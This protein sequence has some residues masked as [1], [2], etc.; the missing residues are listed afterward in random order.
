MPRRSPNREDVEAGAED[1]DRRI[2]Q[3]MKYIVIVAIPILIVILIMMEAYI[4]FYDNTLYR[5]YGLPILVLALALLILYGLFLLWLV[6]SRFRRE[7]H[8]QYRNFRRTCRLFIPAFCARRPRRIHPQPRVRVNTISVRPQPTP[9][10]AVA[11]CS[12]QIETPPIRPFPPTPP[13]HS[14]IG[15]VS[16]RHFEDSHRTLPNMNILHQD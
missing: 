5:R 16:F 6:D 8:V 9:P 14:N 1:R 4:V 10:Y 7:L 13:E 11:D 12:V 15:T 2:K 3:V